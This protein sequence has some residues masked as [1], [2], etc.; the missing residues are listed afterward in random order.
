MPALGEIV[1]A[2]WYNVALLTS[3]A[4]EFVTRVEIFRDSE[5][6]PDILNREK[7]S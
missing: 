3:P 1:Q 6:C 5:V 7:P 4:T 2:W